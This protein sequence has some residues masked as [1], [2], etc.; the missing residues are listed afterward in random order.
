MTRS[1]LARRIAASAIV[2]G[3]AT[4]VAQAQRGGLPPAP[5]PPR[6]AAPIDLTGY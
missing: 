5:Q 2:L 3:L 4:V 1:H 6:L